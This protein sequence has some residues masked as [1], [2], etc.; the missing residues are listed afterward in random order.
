MKRFILT[1]IA[2]C[3]ALA[4][5]ASSMR[6]DGMIPFLAITGKPT[7][8][9]VRAKVAAIQAQGIESFLIY[10]RSGLELEYMGEEWLKLNEWF[11]DE[12]EKRGMKVW[13]YDEYN[14]PS[15]TCKG[16][17]PN[18]N[19]AWRY[20]EY[21][22]YRNPDGSY[23]WTTA[24]A[25]GGWV[26]VCEPAAV[27]RFIEL[28]HEVYAKRLD[29]WFKN[30]T[31]LGI[32]TDEPGHPTRVTFPDGKPLV[33]FRKYSGLEEEYK[34]ATGRELK[35]DVEKWLA[36]KEGDVW[37]VYL[38]LMGQRFRTSYFDQL[39]A[40]CD[41]H[42]I[43]LTGHMI[44]ENDLYGSARC[45]GNPILC[46]RG[47]SLPGMDEIHTRCEPDRIEWVTY[48]VARQA[49]LHRGNGGLAE[50]YACG[51][52]NHVPAT[53][54]FVMWMCAFHG[55]DHYITCMDVMDEKG[56]VEK[57][58]YLSCM[59]PIHPWYE[60]HA[61]VLADEARVAAEWARKKVS[62]REV[63]VRYPNRTAQQLAIAGRTKAVPGP[64]L[65]GLLR[66]LEL[67]QF[68]CRLVDEGE[69]TDLPLVFT[70]RS[71]GRYA[72]ER[73]GKKDLTAADA[74]ALCRERLPANFRVLEAT[75]VAGSRM[76]DAINCVP[77]VSGSGGSQLVATA[78]P[79]TDLLVRTYADGSAAVL[80]LQPFSDRT[81]VAERNGTR[82]TFTLPARGV[83]LFAMESRHLG[84]EIPA[85]VRS[86]AP[87][88]WTLTLDA[89]N[90]RRVNF[91]PSRKG[92]LTV[93][94]P[95]KGVRLLTRDC[96]MSY[97]V[98]SSGR[99]I[100]LN[101][102][103]AKGDTV[104]RHIAEPYAF[105]MDG[106]KVE[107]PEPCTSLRPCYDPLYRQTKP[108]DLAPGEHA[109]AITSGEADSNFFLPAL[110]LTGD[111]AVFNGVVMPRPKGK[112][113]L[114]PLAA[115]GLAD[116]TGTA[117]WSAEV[118]VPGATSTHPGCAAKMAAVPVN[119][120]RLS[121]GGR[122]TQ[123]KL[124]GRDLGVRTWAPFEWDVP[125]DLAGKKAKLEISVSTS[126]QPMFGDPANGTWDMRFWN[127]VSGP[128]GPCGL[129]AADWLEYR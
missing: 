86:L 89:P 100:G 107:S 13:L 33:S 96:A 2:L 29:R 23:R 30:K 12:A 110:F 94:A 1:L 82:T 69:S 48:N 112:V 4:A 97:A 95:L 43:L 121:T 47:E 129:L 72:E 59:G 16:R 114:G 65:Q 70:C 46:L 49:I 108:F 32:F 116:F 84:G 36:T 27:G 125:A 19:D 106:A 92:T 60:K 11:C 104:I 111:F 38:G 58:G 113:K 42:G 45:N 14:W 66:A 51:P 90:I 102:Q 77:P 37:S 88:E 57:H 127:A 101:E 78:T 24:L 76:T 39:R 10:A 80:N 55:I 3:C 120:L 119:R 85:A 50:L 44:S 75:S 35:A 91:D 124:A 6:G 71:D 18:E 122:L 73:T 25:P 128:D 54:R 9:E 79:A 8:A 68:T 21:G 26:N 67:N 98:T 40:W 53:L 126:V 22:V 64:N 20:T 17:V 34:A 63:A 56:L 109:F 93:A 99:P 105:E 61:R 5:T 28:T 52:A 87:V 103:P 62:E 7:E 118:T 81:L 74:L 31:I 83:V 123:V 117:T 115:S 15:G 41:A